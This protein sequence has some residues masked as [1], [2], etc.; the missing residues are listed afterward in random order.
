MTL[1]D[2]ER[3][4][5]RQ[6]GG[7]GVP[8]EFDGGEIERGIELQSFVEHFSMGAADLMR[9]GSGDLGSAKVV[10]LQEGLPGF[11]GEIDAGVEEGFGISLHAGAVIAEQ[12]GSGVSFA[13]L[14]GGGIGSTGSADQSRGL[15]CEVGAG[16]DNRGG[17]GTDR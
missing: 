2:S 4:G 5:C 14:M 16:E 7:T 12:T 8:E 1:S 6:G 10:L 15:R 11:F 3:P 17:A 13:K 9:E